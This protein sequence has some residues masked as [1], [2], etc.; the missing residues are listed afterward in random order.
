[1]GKI[2]GIIDFSSARTDFEALVS[3]WRP[4]APL[5]RGYS[6]IRGGVGMVCQKNRGM[7]VTRSAP[8]STTKRHNCTVMLVSPS[9]FPM[10]ASDILTI[11]ER[12]GLSALKNT[13]Y[14]TGFILVDEKEKLVAIFTRDIPIYCAKAEKKLVF[15]SS[16]ESLC[17]FLSEH[18]TELCI[19]PS[20]ISQ[21]GTALFCDIINEQQKTA[22]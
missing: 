1:M 7:N 13:E 6:Y 18:L 3:L 17:T 20:K 10:L 4:I 12:E 5:C 19:R 9:S 21:N 14:D 11:Y 22:T 15:S 8:S 16:C 2:C